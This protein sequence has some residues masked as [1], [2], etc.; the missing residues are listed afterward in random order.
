MPVTWKFVLSWSLFK[1]KSVTN[2]QNFKVTLNIFNKYF[3]IESP[4]LGPCPALGL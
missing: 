2:F 1:H 3:K 4:R